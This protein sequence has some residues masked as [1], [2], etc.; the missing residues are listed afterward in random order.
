MS[1]VMSHFISMNLI[2]SKL[3]A[4]TNGD[5]IPLGGIS[6]VDTPSVAFSDVY[7]ISSLTM[8]LDSVSKICDSECDV[9]FS[10]FDC[11]IYDQKKQEV[12][13]T[14]YREGNLYVLDYF[15]DIHDTAS[16]SVNLSSFWLNRGLENL[17]THDIS[18][19]S[20]RKLAKF[21]ALS[22]NNSVSSLNAP[23]FLVHYDVWGPS[24]VS[25]KGEPTPHASDKPTETTTTIETPGIDTPPETTT[26]TETPKFTVSKATPTITQSSADVKVVVG[27][28]P[29][30]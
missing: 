21:S 18:D 23:F 14:G 3:I 30:G 13:G 1:H 15:R 26:T 8:N 22:F 17:D 24:P 16:S 10:V 11:S 28:P 2:S 25:T 4:A 20:S 7:Y 12:V 19:C 6:S 29:S 27:P 9:K 5:S